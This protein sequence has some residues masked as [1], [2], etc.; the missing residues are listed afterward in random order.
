[1]PDDRT[2][3][4]EKGEEMKRIVIFG[5]VLMCCFS[6]IGIAL[7]QD[8]I[9]K[10]PACKYCGMKPAKFTHS[11]MLIDYDNGTA[12][13]VCSIHCAAIDLSLNIDRTP[14]M[15]RVGDFNTKKL[16]DAEKAFWVIGGKK[17]GVMTKNAKWA[18]EIQPDAEQ[19]M[20]ANG[21]KP[22][23]LDQAMKAAYEDMYTDTKMIRIKRK[24]KKMKKHQ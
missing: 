24:M 10:F 17:M 1:M 12:V 16:I 4:T 3:A 22:A 19:F 2:V 9:E 23:T 15:I 21:G 7:A 13:G 6:L 20:K 18:F 14:K 11:R 8:D 5:I